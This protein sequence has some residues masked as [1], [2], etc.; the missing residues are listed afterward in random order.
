MRP[1][2][3]FSL[4]MTIVAML[5]VGATP[6]GAAVNRQVNFQGKIT[7]PAGIAVS[8]G[9]YN[10]EFKL[11]DHATNA[12]GGQG[13]CVGS[14]LWMETRT[15]ANRVQVTRGMF[16]VQLGDV[17][18]LAAFDFDRDPI[19][20][21]LRIGGTGV[22]PS[23]DTEMTPRNRMG[24]APQA[25]VSDIARDITCADCVTASDLATDA[26]TTAEILDG[27]VGVNDL[28]SS[29][30]NSAKIVD[31]SI[32]D[33]DVGNVGWSK[34]TGVPARALSQT[35]SVT[36]VSSITFAGLD[37]AT[38]KG[39]VVDYAGRYFAAGV[40]RW[41]TVHLNGV[42]NMG[43]RSTVVRAYHAD[44]SNF[45]D[46]VEG[47]RDQGPTIGGT[48]WN[49]DCTITGAARIGGV[50]G[51]GER[52][53]DATYGSYCPASGLGVSTMNAKTAGYTF[54]QGGTDITSIHVRFN[55]GTFT[56]TMSVRPIAG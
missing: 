22:S 11:H 19:H 12:G 3:P 37:G 53:V 34:L 21:S 6:A 40:D 25:I 36:N 20:L 52:V 2:H 33:A 46:M 41:M 15:G 7:T 45:Q 35:Q 5:L 47:P 39:F 13:S 24:A 43:S 30:V 23:W 26:V 32:V 51:G 16:S 17:T 31:G 50:G 29:S 44:N 8:D 38:A 14:C 1:G 9:V 27:T 54:L 28:A 56:G 49:T 10:I 18:S 4:F 48:N 42:A 55:G